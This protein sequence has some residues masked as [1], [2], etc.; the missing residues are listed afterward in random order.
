MDVNAH[1]YS[2]TTSQDGSAPALEDIAPP[3]LPGRAGADIDP[4]ILDELAGAE[5]EST[6]TWEDEDVGTADGTTD[7]AEDE[8]GAAED[9]TAGL[10]DD[11]AGAAAEDAG[12]EAADDGAADPPLEPSPSRLHPVFA[13]SALGQVTDFQ[14]TVGLSAPSKKLPKRKLQPGSSADGNV[15]HA[16]ADE[17]PPYC[18]PQP[19]EGAPHSSVQPLTKYCLLVWC[20]SQGRRGWKILHSPTPPPGMARSNCPSERSPPV[21][22]ACTIIFLPTIMDVNV[23]L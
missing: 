21:L 17:T 22:V 10:E 20:R 11:A 1:T 4:Y 15:E 2:Y 18:S 19:E 23:S 8:V 7:V 12:V 9:S 13:V 16:L 5:E 3:E 14:S 6:T